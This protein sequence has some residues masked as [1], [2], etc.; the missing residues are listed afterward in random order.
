MENE[1]MQ[2]QE[3]EFIGDDAPQVDREEPVPIEVPKVLDTMEDYLSELGSKWSNGVRKEQID[4]MIFG[5]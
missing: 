2:I 3:A 5:E 1:T 4:R